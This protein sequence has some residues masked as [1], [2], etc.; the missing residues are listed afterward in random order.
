MTIKHCKLQLVAF[1]LFAVVVHAESNGGVVYS[2][3]SISN[4]R[5]EKHRASQTAKADRLPTTA[6]TNQKELTV[7]RPLVYTTDE[8]PGEKWLN[9]RLQV[10]TQTP[11]TRPTTATTTTLGIGPG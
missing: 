4:D 5:A 1:V 3:S 7:S 9:E 10:T 11:T 6:G 8:K 2:S